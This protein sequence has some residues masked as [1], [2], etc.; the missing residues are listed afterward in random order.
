M[1]SAMIWVLIL[2]GFLFAG[3]LVIRFSDYLIQRSKER[4][5][6]W[7]SGYLFDEQSDGVKPGGRT[8][9][10]VDMGDLSREDTE[11]VMEILRKEREDRE[12]KQSC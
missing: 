5:V 9:F 6:F 1:T 8:V 2:G 3:L 11:H 7:H 12:L 10:Y 4:M